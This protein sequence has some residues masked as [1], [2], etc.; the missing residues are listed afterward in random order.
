MPTT[1]NE[2]GRAISA[3][4]SESH[5]RHG[6]QAMPA[7]LHLAHRGRGRGRVELLHGRASLIGPE[8][9]RALALGARWAQRCPDHLQGSRPRGRRSSRGRWTLSDHSAPF[10]RCPPRRDFGRKDHG[11]SSLVR[12]PGRSR[13]ID[14]GEPAGRS[15]MRAFGIRLYHLGLFATVGCCLHFV[16]SD[17]CQGTSRAS[18]ATTPRSP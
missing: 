8:E 18:R 1:C 15:P 16:I 2:E 12:P 3:L 17:P 5:R 13:I 14:L 9:P 7:Q 11:A 6:E 10:Y 4:V